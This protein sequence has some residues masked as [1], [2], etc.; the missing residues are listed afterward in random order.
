MPWPV[1]TKRPRT[2]LHC[3]PS[4][5][6]IF[7]YTDTI[8]PTRPFVPSLFFSLSLSLSQSF[9]L[10]FLFL[11]YSSPSDGPLLCLCFVRLHLFSIVARHREG[12]RLG[13][14]L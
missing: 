14:L 3:F 5:P 4:S 9:F 10:L 13:L 2:D 8:S 1:S 11:L 7:V 6:S 12:G